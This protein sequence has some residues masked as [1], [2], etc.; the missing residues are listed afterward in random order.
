MKGT[1]DRGG[2]ACVYIDSVILIH[3]IIDN[4]NEVVSRFSKEV[5]LREYRKYP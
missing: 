5:G 1:S 4:R 2:R 3:I